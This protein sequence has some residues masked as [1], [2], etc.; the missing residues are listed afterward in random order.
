MAIYRGQVLM[1]V[2]NVPFVR[3]K[4]V[5]AVGTERDFETSTRTIA[6]KHD[7]LPSIEI[8]LRDEDMDADEGRIVVDERE[9]AI[10]VI[11]D[12][13]GTGIPRTKEDRCR[14]GDLIQELNPG[15]RVIV[16][17]EGIGSP[18]RA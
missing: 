15:Y 17:Y 8:A 13:L 12:R 7:L 1:P 18:E 5:I 6:A 11:S 3:G 16:N 10:A 9:S 4:N 14:T 2:E